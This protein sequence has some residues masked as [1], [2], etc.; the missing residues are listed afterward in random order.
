MPVMCQLQAG[1][2]EVGHAAGIWTRSQEVQSKEVDVRLA[3][4][5]KPST[6]PALPCPL[7]GM[8][9][10]DPNQ[11]QP[12]GKAWCWALRGQGNVVQ[13]AQAHLPKCQQVARLT[14]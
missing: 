7:H 14:S 1:Q 13:L 11:G 9:A 8:E 5:R 6:S 2:Q 10:I 4:G 12:V 3:Q